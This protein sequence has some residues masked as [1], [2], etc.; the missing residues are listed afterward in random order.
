MFTPAELVDDPGRLTWQAAMLTT[1]LR[2]IWIRVL[3][4]DQTVV[5]NNFHSND[6]LDGQVNIDTSR[7]A[8]GSCTLTLLDPT[9]S[10]GWE[11]DSP[12]DFP[13]LRRMV[14]VIDRRYVPALGAWI[15]CPVFTGPV[16]SFTRDGATVTINADSKDRLALSNFGTNRT[17]KAKQRV[18]DIIT[19]MLV[20]YSGEAASRLHLP[21]TK[22][23]I[24]KEL[25]VHRE[26]LIW[27]RVRKLA[28]SVGMQIFYDG[29]GHVI[30]RRAPAKSNLTVDRSSLCSSV[31]IDRQAPDL[32]NRW[33]VWGPKPKG[34]KPRITAD[35]RLPAKHPWSGQNLGR[36]GVPR[37][38]L[39]FQQPGHVK[40]TAAAMAI[41]R[42]ARDE[43]LKTSQQMSIDMLPLPQ[44]EPFDLVKVVDPVIGTFLLRANQYSLPLGT[45]G[46][47]SLGAIQRLSMQP[48]HR[49]HKHSTG[50]HHNQKWSAA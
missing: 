15:D 4:L 13:H 12:N 22:A 35:L 18:T 27:V 48:R 25:T 44:I 26:D 33:V 37:W 17:W 7:D 34:K 9:Q 3:T 38:L 19:D 31:K 14:Q 11:P 23:T 42:K 20:G 39:D 2:D 30:M 24:P 10:I 47:A 45:G 41:A 21:S 16:M 8:I 29:R 43:Q 5:T 40:N 46:P 32:K 36:N 1:H 50:H 6:L 28:A 49:G